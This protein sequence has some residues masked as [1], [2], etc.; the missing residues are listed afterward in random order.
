M[1]G[2]HALLSNEGGRDCEVRMI[3]TVEATR[4]RFLLERDVAHAFGKWPACIVRAFE[5]EKMHDLATGN[6][7]CFVCTHAVAACYAGDGA[8][9]VDGLAI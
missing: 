1:R 8:G 9:H 2:G 6:V 5:Q 7:G 3:R 4:S